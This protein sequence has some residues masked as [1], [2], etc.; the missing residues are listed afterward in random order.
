MKKIIP[1]LCISMLG[2]AAIGS[3]SYAWFSMNTNVTVT[4]MSVKAKVGDSLMIAA[5]TTNSTAAEAES[6]FKYG[7]VTTHTDSLVEPVSSING[8]N[9]FYNSTKNA[10]GAGKAVEAKY[11]EYNPTNLEAFRNNYVNSGEVGYVDYA[12][13]LKASNANETSKKYVN[14]DSIKLTYGNSEDASKAWRVAVFVWDMGE[15]GKTAATDV[16]AANLL[17]IVSPA[18][19]VN[20]TAGSAVK[21]TSIVDAVVNANVACN[22]G[23]VA[24]KKVNYYK[25]VTRLWLEGEDKTCNNDT[26]AK[27]TDSWAFD[28]DI[29]MKD[30]TGGATAITTTPT[31]AKINLVGATAATG[32]NDK[33][34]DGVTY[35]EITGHTGYYVTKDQTGAIT[36]DS[37]IYNIVNNAIYDVTNQCTLVA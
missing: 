18:G 1:T 3:A 33:V 7:M 25:V 15:D 24:A 28:L 29:S 11:Q 23:E 19:A 36:A 27:L 22:I 14:I 26:F 9:F 13:Q 17:S 6:A 20:F 2:L 31:S 5:T 35:H 12:F 21:T 8:V 32:A 30:T 16:A 37:I 4:G 10:D 34:I